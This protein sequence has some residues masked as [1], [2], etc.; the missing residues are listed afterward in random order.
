M[1][2]FWLTALHGHPGYAVARLLAAEVEGA[3]AAPVFKPKAGVVGTV[4]IVVVVVV[5]VAAAAA[6]GVVVVVVVVV[7]GWWWWWWWWWWS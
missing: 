7:V 3:N 6:A 4:A 5:V 2:V 1:L